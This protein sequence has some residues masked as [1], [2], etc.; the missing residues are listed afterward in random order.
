MNHLHQ[1]FHLRPSDV[2]EVTLDHAANVL[3]LDTSNYSKY[4]QGD[5]YRYRGGYVKSSPFRISP[6]HEGRWHIV[7][8]LGGQGGSVKASVRV[9]GVRNCSAV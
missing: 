4:N 9:L 2:I 6:P 5:V 1:E 7:V 3:L 8:D